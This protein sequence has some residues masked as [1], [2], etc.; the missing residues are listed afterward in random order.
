MDD[1]VAIRMR[2]SGGSQVAAESKVGR[3]AINETTAAAERSNV[4]AAKATA[5]I[6]SSLKSHA[7]ALK[8]VG[9]S[10]STYVG[11]PLALIGAYSIKSSMDFHEA[12]LLLQT[13]AGA[14]AKE[15]HRL[16]GAVLDFGGSG[17]TIF[18]PTDL[19]KG[20]YAIESA[21]IHGARAMHTLKAASDFALIGQAD[22]ADT[23]KALAGAQNSHIAGTKN[24]TK[25]VGTLNA[26]IGQGQM[27]LSDLLGALSTG[28]LGAG[29]S[30]GINLSDVGA[31]LATLTRAGT[32]ANEVAT[33]LR[34]TL[35]LIASPT[36]KAAKA[37]KGIGLTDTE[38]ALKMRGPAGLMG[39]L[40]DLQKHLADNYDLSTKL[41]KTQARDVL[42]GAFGGAK[43]GTTILQLL[44]NLDQMDSILKNIHK[45]SAE[46]VVK[47]SVAVS[48][49]EDANKVKAA[50]AQVQT[51]LVKLGDV[52]RPVVIPALLWVANAAINVV[53]WFSKLPKPIQSAALA[54][55]GLLVVAGPIM[56]FL[57]ALIGAIAALDVIASPWLLIAAGV[58]AIA[59]GAVYAYYKVKWFHNAVDA[60][61]HFIAK[62]WP[63]LGNYMLIILGPIGLII[64]HFSAIKTGAKAAW[65]WTV[66]AFQNVLNW[67]QTNPLGKVIAA[68]FIFLYKWIHKAL[69]ALDDFTSKIPGLG[70]KG[71]GGF[72]PLG[73]I[74][75]K[76]PGVDIGPI[77]LTP[78][79]GMPKGLL[80]GASGFMNFP[81]GLAV[82]GEQGPELAFLPAGADV[83]PAGPT[84]R[85]R[86]EM[87]SGR[88]AARHSSRQA[89]LLPIQLILDGKTLAE[90]TVQ[91]QED[92]E[93]R[94]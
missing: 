49:A 21:G 74:L 40:R 44:Q 45:N 63:L 19:A 83:M 87:A 61:Y 77:H 79:G 39:A 3:D 27:H 72:G 38:L 26:T 4:A 78:F 5:G 62:Y 34:M 11:L 51:A 33:R 70:G 47:H 18:G 35:S 91:L 84:R 30:V 81:G 60:V 69:R 92:A 90:T 94:A 75:N 22:L 71:G 50:W 56:I 54:F 55:L 82:V 23:T 25:E 36:D 41:G 7:S 73:G 68:P 86:E 53:T 64:A 67:F 20:L 76:V 17:K 29:R 89:R 58:I 13:Q 8:S 43:S 14:S 93:A 10:L 66:T 85:W 31:A 15:V 48:S 88:T 42:A 32:P 80:G 6:S 57:G 16:T 46:G 1:L 37:L 52:L 28:F 24:L 2:L 65:H 12:M 59:V 9:R